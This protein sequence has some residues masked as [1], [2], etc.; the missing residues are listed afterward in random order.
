MK[1]AFDN[2]KDVG[3]VYFEVVEP[4]EIIE[5]YSKKELNILM[6]NL[7]I[8]MR[9]RAGRLFREEDSFIIDPENSYRFILF[10]F[11]PPRNNTTFSETDLKL[12]STRIMRHLEMCVREECGY[13][14]I[15]EHVQFESGY[16]NLGRDTGL[17]LDLL[18][19]TAYRQAAFLAQ[20]EKITAELL[21]NISHELRTPLTCIKGYAESL[22]EGAIDNRELCEKFI[23]II[24]EEACRLERLIND[25]L[26][27]T[28]M[29][30]RQIQM[31]CK[32]TDIIRLINDVIDIMTP[33]A[34]KKEIIIKSINSGSTIIDID[35]DRIKQ[36]LIIL[37]DNAI[38]YS[39]TGTT[40]LIDC[41]NENNSCFLTVEDQGTGIPD[42]EKE[43]VFERFYRFEKNNNRKDGRGLGLSIA[44]FIV[45]SHGG[46]IY[47]DK[48]YKKGCRFIIKL[49]LSEL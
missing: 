16:V 12:V 46:I 24:N 41:K 44:R 28:M 40:V 39:N 2:G 6:N 9:D 36:L 14:E 45:E 15:A 42:N 27:M 31:K 22:L 49:P 19:Y 30:S 26:D 13:R 10:L 38:K 8:G 5:D 32:D 34:E 3:Y 11:S 23:K 25:L 1:S 7:L 33:Y 47:I 43:R 48:G 21:S 35:E 4:D 37:I 29:E 18:I 20:R 17:S